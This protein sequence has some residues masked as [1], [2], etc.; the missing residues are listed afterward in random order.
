[1]NMADY[2]ELKDRFKTDDTPT[3]DDY[4]ELIDLAG[5]AKDEADNSVVDNHD[6][7]ITVNEQKYKPVEDNK[8]G[9]I[10]VN[11][12]K[13]KPV[14]DNEDNTITVN[15]RTFAPVIDNQD[16][17]ITVN[18]Q[19]YE[20][21]HAD[22]VALKSD[23]QYH[24]LAQGTDLLKITNNT[25]TNQ[26]YSCTKMSDAKTMMNVPVITAFILVVKPINPA[27]QSIASN[28]N[29]IWAYSTLEFHPYNTS[30]LYIAS[31]KTD[32]TGQL[33]STGWSR[34]ADYNKVVKD[35]GDGSI[36]I[37]NKKIIPVDNSSLTTTPAFVELQTQVNN[38][39]VGT[40]LLTGTGNHTVTGRT[41]GQ[42]LS[43]ETTDDMLT[44]FKGLEGQ[45]V[46]VSVDYEYSGFIAGSGYNR[47]GWETKILADTITYLGPWYYPNNSSGSGRI[48]STF[49]VPKNITS[50]EYASGWVN[51]SGSG[52]GTV[53]HLKLEKGSLSTDWCPNPSEI[54]TQSDYLLQN[55]YYS[56][57]ETTQ[58]YDEQTQTVYYLT[59]VPAVDETGQAIQIKHGCV[60]NQT[61]SSFLANHP[62]AT[63][64]SNGAPSSSGN[65]IANGKII[66][67]TADGLIDQAT[68]AV[69]KDG[70]LTWYPTKTTSEEMLADGVVNSFTGFWPI[71]VEGK[72]FDAESIA[73]ATSNPNNDWTYLQK[74]HPRNVICQLADKS[75]LFLTAEGRLQHNVGLSVDDLIRIL[76]PLNVVFAYNLDGGG[77]AVLIN[78]GVRINAPYDGNFT[79]ERGRNDFI[80]IDKIDGHTSP[81]PRQQV[82]Y[83]ANLKSISTYNILAH[84]LLDLEHNSN[85]NVSGTT[86]TTA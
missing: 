60:N 20:P 41:I 61:P 25:G 84:Q 7:T 31:T 17:T 1:M 73:G 46:T 74:Q 21:A 48:S 49:V 44:L 35:N 22:E 34:M 39:T 30:D 10:T 38:S 55:A 33:E 75:L 62:T 15:G 66:R 36:T 69:L 77:S 27:N 43:N 58:Y 29:P 40:N 65:I 12:T 71:I 42:Y 83:Q 4:A 11:G 82:N 28:G 19:T 50:I 6:G 9:N 3:G 81:D 32:G 54:L 63:L 8:D 86:G 68:M 51:F 85:F 57:V 5:T 18:T 70:T 23:I 37:N 13:Y 76:L 45:T 64:I 16:G 79:E 56:G 72:A 80:Y 26:Y 59:K 52:T 2:K 14:E 24:V 53:S 78:K 47:L 67:S